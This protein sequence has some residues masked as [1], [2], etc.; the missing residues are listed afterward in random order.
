MWLGSRTLQLDTTDFNSFTLGFRLRAGV[1]AQTPRKCCLRVPLPTS[2]VARAVCNPRCPTPPLR[3]VCTGRVCFWF[4]DNFQHILMIFGIFWLRV[5]LFPSVILSSYAVLLSCRPL[6]IATPQPQDRWVL[7][8][9][10]WW[11]VS[12]CLLTPPSPLQL[13]TGVT[14]TLAPFHPVPAPLPLCNSTGSRVP[15]GP[16]HSRASSAVAL[17]CPLTAPLT[18]HAHAHGDSSARYHRPRP[19]SVG[20]EQV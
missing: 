6:Q 14:N 11:C 9:W 12:V 16:L 13:G 17:F 10:V 15:S 7:L 1:T 5:Y 4:L 18:L 2:S 3:M 20:L 8:C 19:S